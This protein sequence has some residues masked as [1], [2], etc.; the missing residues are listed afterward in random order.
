MKTMYRAGAVALATAGILA[1]WAGA[2]QAVPPPNSYAGTYNPQSACVNKAKSW[3]RINYI[4]SN[5]VC[6]KETVGVYSL[7]VAYK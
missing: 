5:W 2:A 7:W 1:G 6:E 3:V 4:Y